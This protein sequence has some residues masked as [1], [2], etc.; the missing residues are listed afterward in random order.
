MCTEQH[1]IVI[2]VS[3]CMINPIVTVAHKRAYRILIYPQITGHNHDTQPWGIPLFPNLC[4]STGSYS[5]TW[6]RKERCWRNGEE[7]SYWVP[8]LLVG[9]SLVYVFAS[10]FLRVEVSPKVE[11]ASIKLNRG[12]VFVRFGKFTWL[13]LRTRIGLRMRNNPTQRAKIPTSMASVMKNPWTLELSL[14]RC[15]SEMTVLTLKK[16]ILIVICL[17]HSGAGSLGTLN[18]TIVSPTVRVRGLTFH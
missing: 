17:S 3:G 1:A 8:N 4:L 18:P 2:P 10:F 9:Y 7:W 11:K 6:W 5:G 13:N 12:S 14:F 16:L 15:P